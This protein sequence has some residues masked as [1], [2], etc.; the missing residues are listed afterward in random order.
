MTCRF[1][2]RPFAMPRRRSPAQRQA[3]V[4]MIITL[5]ALVALLAASIALVRSFDSSMLQAGS[6]AFKRDLVN[7]GERGMAR[8]MNLLA[9]GA[10]AGAATIAD[11]KKSNYSAVEL[12]S[13]AD[14][15]PVMLVDDKVYAASGMAAEDITDAT[16]HVTIRYVIDRMCSQV[17]AASAGSC[18]MAPLTTESDKSVDDRYRTV[19]PEKRPVYRISVRVTGPRGTQAFF[20]STVAI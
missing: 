2:L 19:N 9:S 20:Q 13:N 15:I 6:L 4:V 14:G 3:G 18:V 11:V 5:I 8:A 7:Q 1:P 17:G 16:A 12:S 10:L